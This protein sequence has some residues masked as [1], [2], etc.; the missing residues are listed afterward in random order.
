MSQEND[1]IDSILAKA[2]DSIMVDGI[3]IN[4]S[5]ELIGKIKEFEDR[6]KLLFFETTNVLGKALEIGLRKLTR[7]LKDHPTVH[8]R[9][10]MDT[11]L[12]HDIKRIWKDHPNLDLRTLPGLSPEDHPSEE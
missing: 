9:T 3:N 6:N 4:V 5:K 7:M 10:L 11:G 1:E 12:P 8:I 2:E